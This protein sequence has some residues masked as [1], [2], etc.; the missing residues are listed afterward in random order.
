[1]PFPKSVRK[2]YLI[3]GSF[4]E[5]GVER[6]FRHLV[7]PDGGMISPIGFAHFHERRSRNF[8]C[9]RGISLEEQSP[10]R[11]RIHQIDIL[12]DRFAD[13]PCLYVPQHFPINR[14]LRR[15]PL[16]LLQINLS[17]TMGDE[18]GGGILDAVDIYREDARRAGRNRHR[19][20]GELHA[21]H[22]K[23]HVLLSRELP[24]PFIV[25]DKDEAAVSL[26]ATRPAEMGIVALRNVLLAGECRLH[27]SQYLRI[28]VHEEM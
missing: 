24:K 22:V 6:L 9:H 25:V 10:R 7:H 16:D 2:G 17:V 18:L 15:N 4:L 20:L 27:R 26:R 1:M 12:V 13:S 23:L 19:T 3:D 8:P 5:V 21:T 14:N 28:V 11:L